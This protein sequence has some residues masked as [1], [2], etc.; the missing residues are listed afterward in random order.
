MPLRLPVAPLA[1]YPR[2]LML[3]N[4]ALILKIPVARKAKRIGDK[5][6]PLNLAFNRFFF[7]R[8]PDAIPIGPPFTRAACRQNQ[9][10]A[11]HYEY[12]YCYAT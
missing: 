1:P 7:R 10:Q 9:Q 6:C 3:H 8:L 12:A 4:E 2:N 5:T 11:A